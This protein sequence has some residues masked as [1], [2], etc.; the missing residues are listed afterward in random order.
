MYSVNKL[1]WEKKNQ[2]KDETDKLR[3]TSVQYSTYEWVALCVGIGYEPERMAENEKCHI[4]AEAKVAKKKK[5]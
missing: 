1:E 3:T 2:A 4:A 5:R